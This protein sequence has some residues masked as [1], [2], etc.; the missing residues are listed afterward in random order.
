MLNVCPRCGLYAEE[1]RIEPQAGRAG[2]AIAICPHCGHGQAF[3]HLPLFVLTGA[4]G[5]GKTAVCLELTRAQLAGVP[6]VPDCVFLEQDIL[7]RPEFA[8]PEGD[9]Y[10]FRNT[11]LRVAKN[12]G[13]CGRPV[14]LCGS[15]VP[16]QYEACPE[17]RYFTVVHYLALICDDDLLQERLRARP[18]WRRSDGAIF[19]DRMA[20]FNRWFRE[21]TRC[22]EPPIVLLDTTGLSVRESAEQVV[23]W[24]RACLQ[25]GQFSLS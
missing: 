18:R 7:W 11:W 17:R 3:R 8:D 24:I 22:A 16:E 19:L 6:W 4:S 12:V 15:A 20:D 9:Y 25:E 21:R 23:G 2:I 1:K 14:V 5:V 13:Q 10:A